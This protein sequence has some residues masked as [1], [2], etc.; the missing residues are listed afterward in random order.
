MSSDVIQAERNDRLAAASFVQQPWIVCS[1]VALGFGP[2]LYWHVVGL[3]ERPHYQFLLFLPFAL[4]ILIASLPARTPAASKP[5]SNLDI[6]FSALML[7]VSAVGLAF[8]TWS[9]SPWIAAV[10]GMLAFFSLLLFI[11]GRNR[12]VR[13]FPVWMFCWIL[14][15]LPFGMDEDLI[16]RLRTVT[17]TMTSA[18]L[19]QLG[20]LHQ[21]YAN[22]I[23]LPGKPL[24]VADACSGIH[25]LYVLMAMALFLAM[26]QRRSL[27]HAFLL[28][29][30]TFGLVLV[31]N[32]AR[33]VTVAAALGWR[34]DLSIGFNHT[35]LGV[36]LFCA[37][38]VLIFTTVKYW[39]S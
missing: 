36:S 7:G 14:I 21:T 28:L 4:W 13:W 26:F 39:V 15:P 3:L 29:C 6:A 30:S 35:L 32:V 18:V 16:V 31:E 27:L 5:A 20:I 10:S 37:S 24:F 9:W 2:L 8:A 11:G 33:I 22:V 1:I 12:A 38:A 23:E 34:M 17:T 19:D 25:S